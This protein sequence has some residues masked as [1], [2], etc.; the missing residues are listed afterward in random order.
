MRITSI[1]AFRYIFSKKSTNAINIISGIAVA[2]IAIGTA[3]LIL[4]LSVF[5]GFEGLI[6]GLFRKFNPDLK[7]QPIAAKTFQED[8]LMIHAIRQLDGVVAVSATLEETTLLEYA[9]FQT[10]GILKGVDHHF[11]AV[12]NISKSIVDG[13]YNLDPNSRNIVLGAGIAQKLSVDP[14]GDL[15]PLIAYITKKETS[16]MG[17]PFTTTKLD[18]VGVFEIQ[19]EFDMEYTLVPLDV[20]RDVLNTDHDL[21]YLEI[22]LDSAV[23]T[24]ETQEKISKIL[25]PLF[26]IKDRYRQD[27]A[28]LK[29]MNLEKW[30]SYAIVSL[31]LILVA[32]NMIGALWM[33]VLDKQKDISILKS[34]GM[35]NGQIKQIFIRSG[36]VLCSLGLGCGVLLAL[37]LYYLQKNVGLVRIPEGFVINT[38]PVDMHFIDVVV[39]SLTV[40]L[41]GWLASLPAASKASQIKTNFE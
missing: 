14:E 13:Q 8:T 30:M 9:T 7:V 41:I 19:Q 38:Y 27:E 33:I 1:L 35:R 17:S 36:L 4:V 34:M 18:P 21:S 5:N 37:I 11:D 26:T 32:F 23:N 3:A 15:L 29:L 28:F 20:A 24:L 16:M 39:V 22:K 12:T 40:L 31:T 2:G 6:T 10:F 25:G